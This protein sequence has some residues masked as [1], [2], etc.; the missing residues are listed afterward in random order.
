MIHHYDDLGLYSSPDPEK[1]NSSK[2]TRA[3]II[4]GVAY[5]LILSVF[6]LVASSRK[7]DIKTTPSKDYQTH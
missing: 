7:T 4:V 2:T 6:Y 1:D 3:L 5:L